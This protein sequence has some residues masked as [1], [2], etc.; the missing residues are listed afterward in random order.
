VSGAAFERS[1]E[2]VALVVRQ[3][4]G[5][6]LAVSDARGNVSLK[7]LGGR[8][9]CVA[10]PAWDAEGRWIYVAPGDGQVYAAEAGGGRVESVRTGAIGCGLAWHDPS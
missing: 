10:T 9:R 6:R 2:R 1:G 4:D 7:P 5:V 8:A 3:G